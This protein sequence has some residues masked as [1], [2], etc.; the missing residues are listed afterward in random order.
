MKNRIY[1]SVVILLALA[2]CNKVSALPTKEYAALLQEF[3]TALEHAQNNGQAVATGADFAT[4]VHAARSAIATANTTLAT[5]AHAFAQDKENPT[6]LASISRLSINLHGKSVPFNEQFFATA[7]QTIAQTTALITNQ[8]VAVIKQSQEYAT[9]YKAALQEI[10]ALKKEHAA[11]EAAYKKLKHQL[12]QTELALHELSSTNKKLTGSLH[13][14]TQLE[15]KSM[16]QEQITQRLTAELAQYQKHEANYQAVIAQLKEQVACIPGLEKEAHAAAELRVTVAQ[17]HQE[18]RDAAAQSQATIA[19]LTAELQPFKDAQAAKVVAQAHAQ[20]KAAQKIARA[21]ESAGTALADANKER[22]ELAQKLAAA[23]E[24]QAATAQLKQQ[25]ARTEAVAAVN[26]HIQKDTHAQ[27]RKQTARAVQE[28]QECAAVANSTLTA[29]TNTQKAP[30]PARQTRV[31]ATKHIQEL[32]RFIAE[33]DQKIKKL[34][35]RS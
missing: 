18:S 33:L 20:E 35:S 25:I 14:A 22:E 9:Q 19:A 10:A 29:S 30:K 11:H 7:A 24:Q 15:Q 8:E 28:A 5:L 34:E 23:L 21:Q 2:H 13:L 12:T 27:Q 17:L 31:T 3:K 26:E 16:E 1:V 32:E 4:T 6:M